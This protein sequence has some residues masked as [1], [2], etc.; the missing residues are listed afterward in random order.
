MIQPKNPK[1]G[2]VFQDDGT[3]INYI[4]KNKKWMIK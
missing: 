1:E 2:D 4:R 3:G